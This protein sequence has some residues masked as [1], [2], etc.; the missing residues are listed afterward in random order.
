MKKTW[1]SYDDYLSSPEWSV[2]RDSVLG[3][4][5]EVCRICGG[6]G[7]HVHHHKYPKDWSNDS[8]DNCF[9]VCT[10]CHEMIHGRLVQVCSACGAHGITSK[11]ADKNLCGYCL[12]CAWEMD[13]MGYGL[14]TFRGMGEE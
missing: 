12:R 10:R 13:S 8:A 7:D 1:A 6:P 9:L 2:I 3:R 4:D 5:E 11:H 14:V